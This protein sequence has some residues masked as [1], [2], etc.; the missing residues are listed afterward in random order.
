MKEQVFWINLVSIIILVVVIVIYS[1]EMKRPYPSW[2]IEIASEP[3]Y[4]FLMYM[5]V[6][7]ISYYNPLIALLVLIVLVAL[8]LDF[9]NLVEISLQ[10]V[11]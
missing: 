5:V 10:K 2:L 3:I 8:H 9:K 6:F 4:L 11:R 1:I 7:A